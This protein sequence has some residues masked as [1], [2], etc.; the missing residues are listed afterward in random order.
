M[1]LTC[2][3]RYVT[4]VTLLPMIEMDSTQRNSWNMGLSKKL[5]CGLCATF[6]Y[7]T[8]ICF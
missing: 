1:R 7:S 5:D 3:Q 6:I 8:N 2:W 4:E